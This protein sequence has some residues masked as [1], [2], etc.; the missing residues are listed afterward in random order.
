MGKYDIIYPYKTVLITLRRSVRTVKKKDVAAVVA[1]LLVIFSAVFAV[2]RFVDIDAVYDGYAP[3]DCAVTA[4]DAGADMIAAHE[5]A[6]CKCMCSCEPSCTCG[7]D[8]EPSPDTGSGDSQTIEETSA[9][10]SDPE[11]SETEEPDDSYYWTTY[12]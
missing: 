6:E 1:A 5:T 4:P 8:S 11:T 3:R 7:I 9:I 10:T 12:Y 2:S